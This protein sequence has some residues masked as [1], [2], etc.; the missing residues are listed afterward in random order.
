MAEPARRDRSAD[1]PSADGEL[2]PVV[3]TGEV[4][5]ACEPSSSDSMTSLTSGNR[6]YASDRAAVR[7]PLRTRSVR[8]YWTTFW[9]IGSYLWLR[10]RARFHSDAWI[11]HKLRTTH[12]RNARRIERTICGLQG[13]F[14][15]VGQLISI[16]TNFLP[17]EF[18]RE[19]EGLQD[20]V[21]PRP[22]PDIEARIKEELGAPPDALFASFERRPIASA[23]IGQV[24]VARLASRDGGEPELVAVK[25]QYPAIDE[26]VRSDLRTLRRIFAFIEHSAPYRGLDEMSRGIRAIALAELDFRDEAD[27][28]DRIA[29]NFQDQ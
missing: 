2:P 12:L 15:K 24:H 9:V 17:E 13:L 1:D 19:L 22:Y 3:P 16:M 28:G 20:T 27:N 26:I 8:A 11:E 14:I 21:P 29:A 23:S 5:I 6:R 7:A 4:A 10:V 25:V 18:R